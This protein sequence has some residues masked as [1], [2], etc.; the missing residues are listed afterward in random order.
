MCHNEAMTTVQVAPGRRLTKRQQTRTAIVDAVLHFGSTRGLDATTVREI[1][2]EA[3]IGARTF[4]RFFSSKEEAV[5]ALD[6]DFFTAILE[7]LDEQA[8]GLS[9]SEFFLGAFEAAAAQF[10][11]AW[12]TR[13]AGASRL[14]AASPTVSG[15]ALN[16]CGVTAARCADALRPSFST[17]AQHEFDLALDGVLN[18]WRRAREAWLES[19]NLD[20]AA[21]H[22][23][24]RRNLRFLETTPLLKARAT[25]SG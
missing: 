17:I 23:L 5:I 15:I 25:A 8:E 3:G 12:W 10:D 24:V 14:A 22:A 20:P 4:F 18:A 21:F 13:F 7:A 19:E 2:D 11:Q 16:L 9:L 6:E 1:A